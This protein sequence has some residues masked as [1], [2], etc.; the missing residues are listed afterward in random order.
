[1]LQEIAPDR[2]ASDEQANVTHPAPANLA[3]AERVA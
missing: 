3:R 1:V 2:R